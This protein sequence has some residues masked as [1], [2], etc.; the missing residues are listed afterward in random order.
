MKPNER[1]WPVT[2]IFFSLAVLAA[3]AVV[4]RQ[5]L[6]TLRADAFIGLLNCVGLQMFLVLVPACLV[7]VADTVGWGSCI[8]TR[9]LPSIFPRLLA[10]RISCDAV[11]N[12]LPAGVAFGE[13]LRAALLKVQF[14]IGLTE[15]AACCLLGKLNLA[16]AHMAYVVLVTLGLL[17]GIGGRVRVERLPGGAAALVAGAA[18]AALVG[19]LLVLSYTG[20]RLSQAIREV[21]RVRI[22]IV[23]RASATLAS[24][25]SRIDE[26]IGALARSHP[27]HLARSI[28]AYFAGWTALASESA[29]IL[30]LLGGDVP[31]VAA[32]EIEA[33]VSVMRI[34]F[35]FL[36]SAVG[37]AEVAY[38]GMLTALGVP[39]PVT[40]SAA[41]ITIKRSREALWILVGYVVLVGLARR[42]RERSLTI[43]PC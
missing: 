18:A 3:L 40:T 5:Q 27:A 1:C 32:L 15:S 43:A 34:A 22:G 9:S 24:P 11:C 21:G 10:I 20:P 16:L 13:S 4:L 14:G 42:P 39:D 12:S 29:L 8:V 33:V 30:Y 7:T 6:S 37:A 2:R 31:L 25:L 36:P 19:G 28:G 23:Q 38:V 35:F 41:F 17:L 26:Q